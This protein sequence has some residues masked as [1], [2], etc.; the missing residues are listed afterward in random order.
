MF[1]R[2][3]QLILL[4]SILALAACGGGG[5][6]GTAGGGGDTATPVSVTLSGLVYDEELANAEVEVFIGTD[7]TP[8]ATGTSDANGEYS[9]LVNVD[10]NR[11]GEICI[12]RARRG[13]ASLETF[14]G[15]V[16]DVADAADDFGNVSAS[17]LPTLNVT[18]I[19]TAQVALIRQNSGGSLPATSDTIAAARTVLQEQQQ[20][21]LNIAAAIKLIIDSGVA[22]PA[23]INSTQE[24]A[25]AIANGSNTSF[26]TDN[27]D[28][29]A[30]AII[31]I[32][33]DPVLAEQVLLAEVVTENDLIG[34]SYVVG[35]DTLIVFDAAGAMTI[36]EHAT[37]ASNAGDTGQWALTY[38]TLT[39]TFSDQEG[40]HTAEV[41]ILGGNRNAIRGEVVFD[42]VS[43]GEQLFRR[44][45]SDPT[46]VDA[47]YGRIGFSTI[48]GY[49]MA[50]P[51]ACTGAAE[52]IVHART[53]ASQV[54]LVCEMRHG[55]FLMTPEGWVDE[56][57]HIVIPLTGTD[58]A[59]AGVSN[60]V[61]WLKPIVNNVQAEESTTIYRRIRVA[62]DR[63]L[64][65]AGSISM[66]ID[67]NGSLTISEVYEQGGL[68]NRIHRLGNDQKDT[69]VRQLTLEALN[70]VNVVKGVLVEPNNPNSITHVHRL[71]GGTVDQVGY[72]GQLLSADGGTTTTSTARVDYPLEP[73]TAADISGKIFDVRDL[74][75]ESDA[76]ITFN[77]D[78]SGLYNETDGTDV[79]NDEF[80]WAI[81]DGTL[82]VTINNLEGTEIITFYKAKLDLGTGKLLVGGFSDLDV[83]GM[84]MTER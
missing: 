73:I 23:G 58:I 55:A 13:P 74:V 70:G 69:I 72:S 31:Q 29:I 28:A 2:I 26:L 24:L 22:L 8:I 6:G 77:T 45:L 37:L 59:G 65:T 4:S 11:T 34:S 52:D 12:I 20:E 82:K 75:Y 62:I 84:S 19:T 36:F 10:A 47:H 42:G 66:R 40:A 21:V 9:F 48:T 33:S 17:S 80:A 51:A 61:V 15:V 56:P 25:A 16:Q 54:R 46:R 60:Q 83:I 64:P 30:S 39:I 78:G 41:S 53:D 35:E 18:N 49:S 7:T 79:V 3:W 67:T 44:V 32:E 57:T 76:V 81:T 68:F 5:G 63:A 43:E 38:P 14:P 1:N 71:T 27:A 50:M